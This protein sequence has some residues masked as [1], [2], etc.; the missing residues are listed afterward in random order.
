MSEY[1]AVVDVEC[2]DGDA[3]VGLEHVDAG[4]GVEGLKAVCLKMSVDGVIP[5]VG[6]LL[7]PI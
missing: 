2:D 1:G 5:L 7:E 3:P 4:V 6:C